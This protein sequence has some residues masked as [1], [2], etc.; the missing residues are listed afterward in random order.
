MHQ[1][2][3]D[4]FLLVVRGSF[5]EFNLGPPTEKTV[6]RL[7]VRKRAEG[8]FGLLLFQ[9]TALQK[10]LSKNHQESQCFSTRNLL[11]LL[12]YLFSRQDS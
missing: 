5:Q 12:L 6:P 10:L 9:N 7:Q 2:S 1:Q 11:L 4:I 8:R 3:E